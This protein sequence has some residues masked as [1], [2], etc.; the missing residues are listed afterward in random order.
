MGFKLFG[1]SE[2]LQED[3]ISLKRKNKCKKNKGRNN[4]F[5]I[6]EARFKA[7]FKMRGT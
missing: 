7:F 5:H 6:K 2:C 1:E 4:K 3:L